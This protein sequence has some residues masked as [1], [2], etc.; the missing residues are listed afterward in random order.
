MELQARNLSLRM[1]GEDVTL[2]QQELRQLGFTIED[3]ESLFGNSTFLAVQEFQREQGIEATGVVDEATAR[4]INAAVDTLQ[5]KSFIV[6]G[7]VVQVDG[8]PV[9][10][11]Q[12]QAV[13]KGLRRETQLGTT[14]PDEAGR[15]KIEY[16]G[17]EQGSISLIV[18]AV[19]SSGKVLVASP[20]ICKAKPVETVQLVVGGSYTGPSEYTQLSNQLIP[21]LRA[22]GISATALTEEDID[23]LT[24]KYELNPEQ[25]TFYVLDALLAT[26][27]GISEAAFY[28]LFRQGL[29]TTL[30]DLLSQDREVLR[31]SLED[32]LDENIIPATLR[33]SLDNILARLQAFSVEY[34]L[35]ESEIPGKF[36]LGG[37]LE[38]AGLNPEKRVAFLAR[39]VA[40]TGSVEEFWSRL[41]ED[42]EFN[43][44]GAVEQL[45]FTLQ[46]GILT[47]NHLPLVGALK[48]KPE[49]NNLRDLARFDVADWLELINN[50]QIGT[51]PDISG[52]NQTEKAENYA[53]A[54][55]GMMET[56]LPTAVFA[57]RLAKDNDS[58]FANRADL[59]R[60]FAN[61]QDFELSTPV[62]GYLAAHPEALRGIED[63]QGVRKELKTTERLFRIAPELNRYPAVRALRRSGITSAKAIREMGQS[64][65]VRNYAEQIGGTEA[66]LTLY[67]N[68]SQT[69]ATALAL[70]A[71]YSAAMN[72]IS[73]NVIDSIAYPPSQKLP[74]WK[75]LFGSAD[76]CACEHCC[77]IYSP[78]AYFVDSLQFLAGVSVKGGK[79]ALNELF[80]K[81]RGDIGNIKLSCQNTNTPLPYI[82]LVNEILENAI[83]PTNKVYQTEGTAEELRAMPEHLNI[84]A[85]QLLKQQKYPWNLPFHLW[86]EEARVYLEHLGIERSDLMKRFYRGENE[87]LV[88]KPSIS[89]IAMVAL[90][91][92]ELEW[93]I[94]IGAD[95]D[96]DNEPQNLWGM[97]NEDVGEASNWVQALKH[98]QKFLEKSGLSYRELRELLL[99]SFINPR[100]VLFPEGRL[101][102]E[103]SGQECDLDKASIV[104]LNQQTALKI[105]RFVRLQRKLGWSIPNL[106]RA[107]KALNG[108]NLNPNFLV[109][110]SHVKQL[111]NDLK[112]PLSHL[113]SW[114][115]PK[116]DTRTYK[117]DGEVINKS[118]YAQVFLNKAFFTTPEDMEPFELNGS[119][120]E[121]KATPNNITEYMTPIAAAL[122]ISTEDFNSLRR[123]INNLLNLGNLSGFYRV[124]SLAKSLHLSIREYLTL[125]YLSGGIPFQSPQET[126]RFVEEVRFV[127]ES[128]FSLS[129]LTYL[130]W[131]IETPAVG[132]A[133]KTDSITLILNALRDG[134]K[135]ISAETTL[136]PDPTGELTRANLAKL[137]LVGEEAEKA[138]TLQKA[139]K[140][141][142]GNQ[143]LPNDAEAFINEQFGA[144]PE[145]AQAMV[146]LIGNN[147]PT[148]PEQRF[149]SVL[150]PLL[151]YLRRYL[152]QNLIIRAMAE[153]LNLEVRA[154]E[155][156]LTQLVIVPLVP[157]QKAI[158]FFLKQEFIDDTLTEEAVK[159]FTLLWKIALILNKL[160]ITP[161]M[162]PWLFESGS[163]LLI[164]LNALPFENTDV[165]S[166]SFS[167]LRKLL[168]LIKMRDAL[169]LDNPSLLK[170]LNAENRQ[171]FAQVLSEL[172]GWSESDLRLLAKHF[173]DFPNEPTQNYGLI[174]L[175]FPEDYR[176]GEAL[177]RFQACLE[178]SKRLGVSAQE[179][180]KWLTPDLTAKAARSIRLAVQAKYGFDQWLKVGSPLRDKI[181]IQQRN[182][183]VSYLV[184]RNAETN[185]KF[186]DTNDLFAHYLIDVEMAPCM[187]TSRIKQAISSVQLFIQRCLMNLEPDVT[188]TTD[189]ADKW[190]SWKKWYRV[191]EANRKVFLYPENWIEPELRDNKSPF[192]KDLESELLQNEVTLETVEAA[193]RRYLEKLDEVARLEISGMYYQKEILHV[194]G[195]TRGIPHIYYYRRWENSADWTPW[196]RVD[197]DI[198]GDHLIP[199]VWNQRLYLFWPIF[200]EKANEATKLEKEG[201]K[202]SKYWQ[203]QLAWSEY[204]NGKWSAKKVSI[205]TISLGEDWFEEKK[206]FHFSSQTTRN[207]EL[208]VI[209]YGQIF[210]TTNSKT[211]EIELIQHNLGYFT[212]S[213]CDG[214]VEAKVFEKAIVQEATNPVYYGNFEYQ[215][216]SELILGYEYPLIFNS[217]KVDSNGK[218][219][220]PKTYIKTLENTPGT[221]KITFP[222]Q[223]QYFVT[224]AP[225][226]YE[227]RNRT[228]FVTPHERQL[229]RTRFN[230]ALPESVGSGMLLNFTRKN[231]EEP[232]I[233]NSNA[234]T[235]TAAPLTNV[236]S[237]ANAALA[238]SLQNPPKN[239]QLHIARNSFLEKKYLFE[240]FYH[241]FVGQ[242]ITH[243]N[244]Y[245]LD[246]TLNPINNKK[247]YRQKISTTFFDEYVPTSAVKSPRPVQD[248]DFLDGAY[249]LYNWEFFFHAPF[250]IA[251][252]LSQNQRF[253][254][255]HRWFHYIF[256]PT[257]RSTDVSGTKR[258]WKIKPFVDNEDT[259]KRIDKLLKLLSE[260]EDNSKEKRSLVDQIDAWNNNPFNPHLIAR[261]RIT[262][263]QKA[264]VMK[265]LDNL[266]AWGDQLFRRDTIE[267]INEATQLYILTTEILGPRPQS[268]QAQKRQPETYNS[269]RDRL[270]DFSNALIEVENTLPPV[271]DK[272]SPSKKK[273]LGI[274][275]FAG[276]A[277]NK[278]GPPKPEPPHPLGTILYFC[279][280]K[281]DK[282]LSYWDTVAD[283]LFKIRNCMNI[284]GVVR[285]LPLFE[286][287]IDPAL[288][289]KAAAAGIDIG[290]AL[291][292]LNAPLPH[293]RFQVVLQKAVEL[294]ADVK[295]LGAALL[296][297]LEKKDAEELSLLRSGHEIKLL[298][299]VRQI[300]EQQIEEA[301]ATREGLIQSR[302]VTE[303]RHLYYASREY[304][305]A[306]EKLHL[307]KLETAHVL[308]TIGQGFELAASAAFSIPE[309]DIGTSGISSPVVKVRFG[310]SNVGQAL[311][312][313]SRFMNFVASLISYEATIASIK[314]GYDRRQDDWKLQEDLAAK[315]LN[316]IDKQIVAAEIRLAIAERDLKNHDLQVENAKEVDTY[317]REKF[318][319]QELY[320]WMVSQI[321][322]LYFQSYQLAYDVAKRTEKAYQF[323]LGITNSKFLQ[324]GYWDSLKTGLLAGDKLHYDLKRMEVAYLDQNKRDYEITKQ[325][326]LVLHNPVA[327]IE[328]KE[329][330]E[331]EVE[332]PEALFDMDYPGHYMRRIKNVSITIPCV[333]GPY[334][335]INCTLTLLSNKTR[336][337]STPVDPYVE[338]EDDDDRFVANFGAIQSITTSTAQNDSGMFELNF[339]DE[340]YLPFEGAGVI[341]RWRLDMPKDCNAFDFDTISDVILKLNYTAREGGKLLGDKAK[342]AVK[343]L[344][345][346]EGL[347]RMFSAKH[348]FP[349]QWY[350]FLHPSDEATAQSMRLDL[351]QER[352]PFQLRGKSIQ[353]KSIRLFLKLKD[354][355]INPPQSIELFVTKPS[356]AQDE[357]NNQNE[358]TPQN[359]PT[360]KVTLQPHPEFA[361]LLDGGDMPS[362]EGFGS[363]S[364]KARKNDMTSIQDAIEDIILVCNYSVK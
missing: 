127:R 2:L 355:T 70:F 314:G 348:E 291:N 226:F 151:N 356:A 277:D 159:T 135:T 354:T 261:M 6:Q 60:F 193:F 353:F 75:T 81:R 7:E 234:I 82:D 165:P 341:S 320:K 343:G 249:S 336:I 217:A 255:A 131:H 264:V 48:A 211:D 97:S 95:P 170:L 284:E 199:V 55:V 69:A 183:L 218:L 136:T 231:V 4:L 45:Q 86:N 15:Y 301:K 90:G 130:L 298:D 349:S 98:A 141:I 287:P 236:S 340:R 155:L 72:N 32:A 22:E 30:P 329:K 286:P 61:N 205:E 210:A 215:K 192:F 235:T 279:I 206:E 52:E 283:R 120:T 57:S 209:C 352:F 309:F 304:T 332:L 275:D 144:F 26:E 87:V 54:M 108:K 99:T 164:N 328:L 308:Q 66:A 36:S 67:H 339:R 216:Y 41:R 49:V 56:T 134:L 197:L 171:T 111:Q 220:T 31:R 1:T 347:W 184:G 266:I 85:Y 338:G 276:A 117:L 364:I 25:V 115:G 256:D 194:F 245:G 290:S 40:H 53:K 294:C 346:T 133:P 242:I 351:T 337:K 92:T 323:E 214:T 71:D 280:P 333:T 51:S 265:Y 318:T 297:A 163:E 208:L 79:T 257:N 42:S 200:T 253:E 213:G 269:L 43:Q 271:Q 189:D 161:V 5:P 129:E 18:R 177:T 180:F 94:I 288:L 221:Y 44:N 267:S 152:S 350:R 319:N 312:S 237:N 172:T 50:Q 357:L 281:N 8:T 292:D 331:C 176:N 91:L 247:L 325:I 225:L 88:L 148:E 39:Y 250:L 102:I 132:V 274:N 116:L 186:K 162:L 37:L 239:G 303:T 13:E 123:T 38:V 254:E 268:I 121:L 27:T 16:P 203:I 104:N 145:V 147:A 73:L 228:F 272:I 168:R 96:F 322:T 19:D 335:S 11:V 137:P 160:A 345:Q 143:P 109:Q 307:A 101:R 295:A 233:T 306:N 14:T 187:L 105:V 124:V 195:R 296:S 278:A 139:M 33:E 100:T 263:Y 248:F 361:N 229:D 154:A 114:W 140:L 360:D 156:L 112:V 204:K 74:N 107:I 185:A 182:A 326:S 311:Q 240:M 65:F 315:E 230:T 252:H 222:A 47:N 260:D 179:I 21:I 270:D 146:Q 238:L 207:G 324:P 17:S 330:G 158:A 258:F 150:Q 58:P 224:Q 9:V 93:N 78:A 202:P 289:V 119:G 241:P 191:W 246:Y 359:D 212:L 126:M 118:P 113:L 157:N 358:I 106:D 35:S 293:Y 244:L 34:A 302:V 84:K 76:F 317:M 363:R 59:N 173:E 166:V 243:L 190:T 174:S 342:D 62:E 64:T 46:L 282:L 83:A 28:G 77:S 321:S 232:T 29:P 23:F 167:E 299:G 305:N 196:E 273:T 300:K 142:Q 327:L 310:G 178:M 262:A 181:R 175:S 223:F 125:W 201:S 227:D 103:F 68:A 128:A 251:N 285:E 153:A 188:M 20:T 334:T 198:E 344:Q 12:V 219:L 362:S 110:L 3:R 10:G 169:R 80:T 138:M 313:H 89:D 63:E 24:C 316:Q 149:S 122:G 259:T